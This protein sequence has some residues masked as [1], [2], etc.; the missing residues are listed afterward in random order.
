MCLSGTTGF[1]QKEV[2]KRYESEAWLVCFREMSRATGSE[3][4]RKRKKKAAVRVC[5]RIDRT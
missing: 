3:G 1:L 5:W 2:T 4:K